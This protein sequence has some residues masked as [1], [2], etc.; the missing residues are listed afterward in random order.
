[1]LSIHPAL[2]AR[3]GAAAPA[4]PLDLNPVLDA[5]LTQR[6]VRHFVP[7]ALPPHALERLIAAAQ[8]APS[9]SNLQTWSVVAVQSQAGRDRLAELTGPQNHLRTAPLVLAFLADLSR[10]QRI[11]ER[12]GR[13]AGGLGYLDTFLMAVIDAALAAQNAVLAAQSL[14]LGTVYLG[15]LRNQPEPVAALLGTPAH[16]FPVFGLVVGWPDPARPAAVKPRLPQSSVLHLERYRA[17]ADAQAET[18]GYDAE[19]RRFQAAEGMPTIDW[20]QQVIDR[21]R[22]PAALKGRHRLFEALLGAGL[23]FDDI[24]APH[25]HDTTA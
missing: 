22:D 21:L 9:S 2:A 17:P 15:A 14:G 3:Y 13:E 11:A 19:L 7:D 18:G 5:L 12:S 10:I 16:V 23:R 4:I 6:S 24:T 1:M 25:H 20:T 8:S